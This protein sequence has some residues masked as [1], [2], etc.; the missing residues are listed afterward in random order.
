MMD[1]KEI[2]I[3]CGFG[4]TGQKEQ[5]CLGMGAHRARGNR[6]A[7]AGL[8]GSIPEAEMETALGRRVEIKKAGRKAKI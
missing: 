4:R 8:R 2:K 3:N 6:S 7:G 5:V 1:V